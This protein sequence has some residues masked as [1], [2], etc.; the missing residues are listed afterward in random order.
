MGKS[1]EESVQ[2]KVSSRTTEIRG[3]REPDQDP[4]TVLKRTLKN[5]RECTGDHKGWVGKKQDTDLLSEDGVIL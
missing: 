3:T 2:G 5:S 4:Q 1:A